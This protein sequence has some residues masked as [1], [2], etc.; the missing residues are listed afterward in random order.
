MFK[1]FNVKVDL[2]GGRKNNKTYQN[3][4]FYCNSKKAEF[5]RL[6]KAVVNVL[7]TSR[8]ISISSST[9]AYC[10]VGST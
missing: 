7:G 10:C 6:K 4:Q 8:K 2:C 5:N 3:S 9:V 1:I